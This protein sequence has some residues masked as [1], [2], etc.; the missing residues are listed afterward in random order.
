[1]SDVHK[2]LVVDLR[3]VPPP[4]PRMT[5]DERLAVLAKV[6]AERPEML[7]TLHALWPHLAP[8][9]EGRVE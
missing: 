4:R 1:M 6:A 5:D 7:P 9:R 8:G 3:A 2:S